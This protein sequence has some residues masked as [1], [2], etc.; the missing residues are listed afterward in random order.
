MVTRYI[1]E[2]SVLKWLFHG[3]FVAVFVLFADEV[4]FYYSS[5]LIASSFAEATQGL[6]LFEMSG[7]DF[8]QVP[9]TVGGGRL[10]SFILQ[11]TN[12]G[13]APF[14]KV[15]TDTISGSFVKLEHAKKIETKVLQGTIDKK[16]SGAT[17]VYYATVPDH[18]IEIK[19]ECLK[20]ISKKEISRALRFSLYNESAI[21]KNFGWEG[22]GALLGVFVLLNTL[23]AIVYR[24]TVTGILN[25]RFFGVPSTTIVPLMLARNGL[26]LL[27]SFGFVWLL[28]QILGAKYPF[29]IWVWSFIS[30]FSLSAFW[31]FFGSVK[32][33]SS[34]DI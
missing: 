15:E 16:I 7:K 33:R 30:S 17:K 14:L 34:L 31:S 20:A 23:F 10:E 2:N 22:A 8:S 12:V 26:L 5:K 4:K 13:G 32:S 28:F 25:L 24:R 3:A 19:K 6:V 29:S 21:I 11:P 27:L 9:R 1:Q 18:A